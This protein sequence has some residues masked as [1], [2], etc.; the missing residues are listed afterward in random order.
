[1]PSQDI[2]YLCHAWQI[3]IILSVSQLFFF[4]KKKKN[5]D[6]EEEA[7]EILV[8]SLNG[9]VLIPIDHDKAGLD[10]NEVDKIKHTNA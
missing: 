2:C 8:Y 9:D 5:N 7:K 3:S 10:P 6:T 1:M 4:F